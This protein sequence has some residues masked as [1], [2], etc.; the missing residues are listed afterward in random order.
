MSWKV[1]AGVLVLVVLV[2]ALVVSHPLFKRY[3]V[4]S[5]SMSPTIKLGQTVNLDR[6]AALHVGDVVVFHPPTGAATGKCGTKQEADQVCARPTSQM[7][8]VLF[9]KRIVAGPGEGIAFLSGHTVRN[10][11]L[12]KEPF[13]TPC[14]DSACDLPRPAHVPDGMYFMVGDNRGASDDSRFWGPV[15]RAYILGRADHCKALYF[16]CSPVR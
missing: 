9:I 13:A 11:K 14:E 5:E 15:P 8:S 10:G 1:G 4:P 12:Q 7:S 16:A 2:V 3:R 6:G